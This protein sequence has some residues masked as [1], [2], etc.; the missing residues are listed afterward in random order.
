MDHD[1]VAYDRDFG[2][3]VRDKTQS[4]IP[5]KGVYGPADLDGFDHARD[6]GNPGEAPFTRG[7]YPEMYRRNLWLKSLIVCYATPEETNRAFK[8]DLAAGPPAGS[9]SPYGF[10]G[11]VMDHLPLRRVEPEIMR[12]R[13]H[14]RALARRPDPEFPPAL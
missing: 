10:L 9:F 6:L 12:V 8:K 4:N 14:A 11:A 13:A 3:L 7:I 5:V 1:S 2:R